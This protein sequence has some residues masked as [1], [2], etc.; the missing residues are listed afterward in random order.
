MP[1][2]VA[3]PCHADA[4]RSPRHADAGRHPRLCRSQQRKTWIPTFV[5]MTISCV[6]MTVGFVSMTVGFAGKTAGFLGVTAGFLGAPADSNQNGVSPRTVMRR[7]IRLS[8]G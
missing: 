6:G 5:G 7:M 3:P 1:T 4:G 8:A 2:K